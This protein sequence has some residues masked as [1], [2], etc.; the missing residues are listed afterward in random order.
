MIV[1][2]QEN[3]WSLAKLHY[4]CHMHAKHSMT[5]TVYRKQLSS[6]AQAYGEILNQLTA[7]N[8]FVLT[9]MHEQWL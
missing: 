3:R 4:F 2:S 6:I 5:H 7:I 9:H 8:V 1:Q